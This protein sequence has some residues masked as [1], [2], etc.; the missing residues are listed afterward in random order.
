MSNE[1]LLQYTLQKYFKTNNMELIT[2][3][4]DYILLIDK[5]VF[6]R[7]GDTVYD[8]EQKTIL[9]VKSDN[10][11][12]YFEHKIIAHLP[13]NNAPLLEG[14]YILPAFESE[15]EKDPCNYCGKTLREQLKGC[16]EITCYRQHIPKQE[17]DVEQ[18][19]NEW[20]AAALKRTGLNLKLNKRSLNG[21]IAG[22]K[23][24]INKYSEEDFIRI[25]TKM[26]EENDIYSFIDEGLIATYLK[27]LSTTAL[28]TEFISDGYEFKTI[29][30]TIQGVEV[31]QILGIYKYE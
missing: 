15:Y 18:L 25:V 31:N 11:M 8:W 4:P 23:A 1:N 12:P 2:T 7:G 26:R 22:Y 16:G 10:T 24:N 29:K 5:T 3:H 13:L 9:K 21:F 20:Y 14:V 17:D 19:A 30:V 6:V 27:S 28:P